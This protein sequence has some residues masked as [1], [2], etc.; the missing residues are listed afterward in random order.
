MQQAHPG[1]GAEVP[2]SLNY[3]HLDTSHF[4]ELRGAAG[5]L[6]SSMCILMVPIGPVAILVVLPFSRNL[7]LYRFRLSTNI[8]KYYYK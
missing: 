7:P 2:E 1:V 5:Y 8:F 4:L 3:A 6:R